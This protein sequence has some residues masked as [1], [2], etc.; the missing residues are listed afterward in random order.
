M[1]PTSKAQKDGIFGTRMVMKI[2]IGKSVKM[3]LS[4]VALWSFKVARTPKDR[5]HPYGFIELS[6][7]LPLFARKKSQ[8]IPMYILREA[9]TL[10]EEA[11]G[12]HWRLY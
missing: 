3:V 5:E 2:I 11:K 6:M 1:N 9:M 4:G 10:A 12:R 8:F 7:G